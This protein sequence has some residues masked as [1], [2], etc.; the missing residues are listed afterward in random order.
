M[1][2][3]IKDTVKHQNAQEII[4]YVHGASERTKQLL[5]V[6][7]IIK[8]ILANNPANNDTHFTINLYIFHFLS[9][10]KSLSDNLAWIIKLYCQFTLDDKKTD[11]TLKSYRDRLRCNEKLYNLIYGDTNFNNLQA[12]KNFRDIIHHKHALYVDRV[13]IGINGPVKIMI[14]LEPKS[15]LL[16]NGKRYSDIIIPKLAE[17]S[18]KDSIAKYG[19][20]K[21][22]VWVGSPVDMPWQD[23][24]EFTQKYIDLI[25]KLYDLAYSRMLLELTRKPIGKVANYYQKIGVGLIALSDKIQTNDKV[26]IEGTSTFLKQEVNSMEINQAKVET[27]GEGQEVCLKVNGRICKGDNVFKII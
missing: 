23:P 3:L 11:L 8:Q 7:D 5:L 21:F 1:D 24:I 12:I 6:N 10:I 14:E 19:M 17:A 4:D 25:G 18:D 2:A 15:N 20:K 16:E 22:H 26:L 13:R 27:A 9:L